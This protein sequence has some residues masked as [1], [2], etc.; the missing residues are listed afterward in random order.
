M[1]NPLLANQTC[2]QAKWETHP[3]CSGNWLVAAFS[4]AAAF[5]FDPTLHKKNIFGE[6]K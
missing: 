4:D 1:E 3:E 6:Y 5:F 2:R